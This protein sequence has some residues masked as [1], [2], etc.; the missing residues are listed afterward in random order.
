MQTQVM[1]RSFWS[2]YVGGLPLYENK[3][4]NWKKYSDGSNS[5]FCHK[6]KWTEAFSDIQMN[7][8]YGI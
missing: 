7:M 4:I 8:Y 3:H 1:A 2:E 6:R 5:D